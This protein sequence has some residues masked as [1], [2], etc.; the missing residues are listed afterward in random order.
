MPAGFVHQR[1]LDGLAAGGF[2]LSRTA[3]SDVRGLLLRRLDNRIREF[4]IDML[5]ADRC[6][7]RPF[8]RADIARDEAQQPVEQDT[9]HHP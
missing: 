2:F 8:Q 3:P 4:G 9:Q 7:I 6:V 1:A 5:C